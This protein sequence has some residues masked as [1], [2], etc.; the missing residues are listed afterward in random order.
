MQEAVQWVTIVQQKIWLCRSVCIKAV[1]AEWGVGSAQWA[2]GENARRVTQGRSNLRVVLGSGDL[3]SAVRQVSFYAGADMKTNF[4][5]SEDLGLAP[6][7][8]TGAD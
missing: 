2:V 4:P 7:R 5:R 8:P 3:I 1:Q 6:V